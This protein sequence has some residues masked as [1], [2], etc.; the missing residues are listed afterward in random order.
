MTNFDE[1]IHCWVNL[2]TAQ[3]QFG[4]FAL[5]AVEQEHRTIREL[6]FA[7]CGNQHLEDTI[8]RYIQAAR[9]DLLIQRNKQYKPLYE[10]M[11]DWLSPSHYTEL[12]RMYESAEDKADVM[13]VFEQTFIRNLRTE[14]VEVR[15]VEWLRA[16]RAPEHSTLELYHRFWKQVSRLLPEVYSDLERKGLQATK[17]DRRRVR[18]LKLAL[19][20][21]SA[22]GET[23]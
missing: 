3:L 4:H 5:A 6:S 20:E 14:I 15:P 8:G 7:I 17:R 19:A 9:W 12:W 13:D 11:R 2:Q 16:R 23:E 1:A 22:D 21:F 10:D 18:I